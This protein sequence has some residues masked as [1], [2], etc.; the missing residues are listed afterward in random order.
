MDRSSVQIAEPL[1]GR[2]KGSGLL[3][4]SG[5]NP[6]YGSYCNAYHNTPVTV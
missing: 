1:V 3:V 5:T 6:S 2:T 4:R